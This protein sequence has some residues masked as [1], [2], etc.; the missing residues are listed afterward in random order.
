MSSKTN[1]SMQAKAEKRSR[2]MHGARIEA[3]FKAAAFE[4]SQVKITKPGAYPVY[5][6]ERDYD[7][8]ATRRARLAM[9][10]G[11]RNSAPDDAAKRLNALR[12]PIV[13]KKPR[14]IGH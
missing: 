3:T 4:Y 7:T 14:A 1:R 2:Q 11:V 12:A 13:A 9:H 10:C 8:S 5:Y 6:V